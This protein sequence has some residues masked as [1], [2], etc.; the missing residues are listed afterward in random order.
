MKSHFSLE[1]PAY[2]AKRLVLEDAE[3]VQQLYEQCTEFA[4][5][6]DGQP[7]LPTAAREE[8]DLKIWMN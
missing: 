8:F 5:L 7:P 2:S 6:T 1:L 4:L 3:V